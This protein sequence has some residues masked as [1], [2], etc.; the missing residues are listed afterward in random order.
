MAKKILFFFSKEETLAKVLFYLFIVGSLS[1]IVFSTAQIS[2]VQVGWGYDGSGSTAYRPPP[3]P[4]VNGVVVE[5]TGSI[6]TSSIMVNGGALTTVNRRVTLNLPLTSAN[7]VLVSNESS[8]ESSSWINYPTGSTTDWLVTPGL[9]KKTIYVR[10]RDLTTL[11]KTAIY[12]GQIELVAPSI[13]PIPEEDM[14]VVIEEKVDVIEEKTGDDKNDNKKNEGTLTVCPLD[15]Q[16]AYRAQNSRAVWYITKKC[17]KRAFLHSRVFFTY[18]DAWDR[19]KVASSATL[20]SIENDRLGFMPWGHLRKYK[21]GDI[22][23]IT[24]DPKVYII[25]NGKKNWI[26]SESVFLSLYKNWN[27]VEDVDPRVLESFED[28]IEITSTLAHP[29]GTLVKVLG[30]SRV[31]L[32]QGGKLRWLVNENT[33]NSLGYRWDRIFEIGGLSDYIEGEDLSN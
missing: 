18:F 19:V 2:P 11:A 10:F 12:T 17:T 16:S 4:S 13:E 28:G 8:F 31:Y 33:F 20:D 15:V 14:P 1:V 23:K 29:D 26:T 3:V 25:V 6:I 30:N 7:Q 32:I 9:G 22:F 21:N 24:D 5:D 27:V